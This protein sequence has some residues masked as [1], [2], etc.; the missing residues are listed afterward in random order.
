MTESNALLQVQGLSIEVLP[1]KH[2]AQAQPLVQNISFS[3][4]AGEILA[5]VGESGSGKSITSLALMRLLPDALA[6]SA[7]SVTLGDTDVFALTERQMNDVRGRQVAM[8]FQEPQSSL[9]PVQTIGKQIGEV[10]Q[11]HQGLSGTELR[12][13]VTAL[14]QEVGIPDPAQRIDWY[15]HQLSGGQKQRVMIAM[16]LACEPQLLIAD[17]PTTALDVTIQ[18]Q[19]LSLLNDIRRRRQLAILLIT[20][21]MG[22]V[23]EMADHVAVMRHGQIIE[24]ERA[25]DFFRA[26]QQEY[27]RQLL[28]ALPDT[29]R[30]LTAADDE[31]LLRL[32][33]VKVWFAQRAGILQRVT[34]YTRAVDGI[35][36]DIRRGETL[37]LVGE[38][39]SGK[40]TAGRAILALEPLAGGDI[41]FAGQ[42][43]DTLSSKEF[44]PLRKKI[45]VIFQDPFSSMNPR[46]SVRDI[47]TEGM[48]ALGVGNDDADREQRARTLLEKVGLLPEHLDRYPHEFSGGQR[49]RLAI[50]RALAVEPELI[51]CDEPTSAL[52]VSI[53][54]Q[55]L[56]LLQQLQQELGLA[57]LFI[58]HDL[59]IIP[60]IAHRVAVMKD[61]RIVEQGPAAT[62][63]TAAEN[64]YTRELLASVPRLLDPAN[65]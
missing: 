16:A 39:G 37:A 49:Q 41:H 46:F 27:S 32:Q 26:P 65:G 34:G 8:V 64:T 42:R 48:Q 18:K 11:W 61:G 50:A 60:Q 7:G 56:A 5:L 51:I 2:S 13:R 36:L 1:G 58:T 38:S 25:A 30:F 28:A 44:F 52:D 10:L 23:A 54:G 6:I 9:N 47:L 24:Q 45:Q 43:I 40:S 19:I 31:P 21:D 62:I 55:V 15:P 35:S 3:L 57:Y 22:V 20:H 12:Q 14:L 17:E 59:S 53:R 33:D 29:S 63:M 4:K